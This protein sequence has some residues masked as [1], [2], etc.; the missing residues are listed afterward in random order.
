MRRRKLAWVGVV[1]SI[2]LAAPPALA[3]R[4]KCPRIGGTFTFGQ[5][6]N[7]NSLDMM[8]S[9]AIS[10][11]NVAMNIFETLVTRGDDN[12]PT[13]EL[14]ELARPIAGQADLHLQIAPGGDVPQRQEVDIGRRSRVIR[15]LQA[16]RT[17]TQYVG[18][19]GELG[20][21]RCR[22]LCHPAQAGAADFHRAAQLVQRPDHHHPG[23]RRKRPAGAIEDHRHRTVATGQLHARQ[24]SA[25]EALR[26]LRAKHALRGQER[27]RRLQAGLLRRRDLS[28]RD[29]TA[30][31]RSRDRNRRAAGS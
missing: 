29:R 27:L 6:A 30:G 11:R 8:V 18:Q 23:R 19:R 1:A 24:P 13:L 22:D 15:A 3:A 31:A 5:E 12:R 7:V 21:S 28:H 20:G 4:F 10:T 26:R 16:D 17:A 9:S 25:A 14:A 2:A